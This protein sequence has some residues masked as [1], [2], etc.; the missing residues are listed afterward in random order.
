MKSSQWEDKFTNFATKFANFQSDFTANLALYTGTGVQATVRVLG[1]LD[2]KISMLMK[3]VFAH[4]AS[5]EENELSSF[6]K[7]KGGPE[8]FSKDDK[9]LMDLIQK[10]KGQ[11]ALTDQGDDRVGQGKAN[12]DLGNS[13]FN[14][15]KE[16]NTNLD[17]LLAGSKS[18]FAQKFEEQKNQIA[19][20]KDVIRRES[21]R[22]VGQLLSGAHD[23][24]LDKVNI[25][26]LFITK[27]LTYL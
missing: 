13:A 26:I 5:P 6:I 4:F 8:V 2:D 17:V 11:Q 27:T 15:T 7:L 16:L 9:L 1:K 14:D 22:I 12:F 18:F 20:V 24:I 10:H 23:R 25:G 3:V 19:E 21:D